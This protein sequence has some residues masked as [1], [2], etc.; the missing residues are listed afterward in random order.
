MI[1]NGQ[2]FKISFVYKTSMKYIIVTLHQE[3]SGI[4]IHGEPIT[5]LDL[6]VQKTVLLDKV[7]ESLLSSSETLPK[8]NN[9]KERRANILKKM[10]VKSFTWLAKNSEMCSVKLTGGKIIITP[11]AIPD[12]KIKNGQVAITERQREL[13]Y[14]EEVRYKV[15]EIIDDF[16]N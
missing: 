4:F 12:G 1:L 8:Y 16:L 5:V 15:I 2:S 3:E 14:N 9:F 6:T 7:F 10:Q 11:F 13:P